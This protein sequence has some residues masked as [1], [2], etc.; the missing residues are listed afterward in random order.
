MKEENIVDDLTF[1]I[2]ARWKGSDGEGQILAA[3]QRIRYS[4]PDNMGGRGV[5]TNPEQLLLAAVTACYS[6]TLHRV[7]EKAA[8]PAAH[9]RVDTVGTVENFPRAPRFSRIVVSPTVEGGDA[10]R[11]AEYEAAAH[12]ARDLCF[13]G[14][15]VRDALDYAVGTVSVAD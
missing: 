10:A 8:L 13:I 9:V 2:Q 11:L 15:T 6:G 12:R 4:G 1:A 3:D 14:R 5:G 7:L